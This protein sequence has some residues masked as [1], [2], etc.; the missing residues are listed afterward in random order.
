MGEH[1]VQNVTSLN[2][3]LRT[4]IMTPV[5]P[6][7]K[8]IKVEKACQV[9]GAP[10]QIRKWGDNYGERSETKNFFCSWGI[11]HPETAKLTMLE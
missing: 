6:K 9:A 4:T 3:A 7:Y 10:T 11:I 5:E 2:L 8:K 1:N